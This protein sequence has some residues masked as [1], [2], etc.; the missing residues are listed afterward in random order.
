MQHDDKPQSTR[1]TVNS[2]INIFLFFAQCIGRPMQALT[3][4]PGSAGKKFFGSFTFGAGLL[5]FLPAMAFAIPLLQLP[6]GQDGFGGVFLFW[7]LLIMAGMIQRATG[8]I[9]RAKGYF[10]HTCYWG[11]A[12]LPGLFTPTESGKHKVRN[13]CLLSLL[14]GCGFGLLTNSVPLIFYGWIALIAISVQAAFTEMQDEARID[15]ALDAEADAE[16]MAEELRKRRE[17]RR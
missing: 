6:P 8:H 4:R 7:L 3:T 15:A 2:G 9:K 10:V 13:D 11:I 5:M 14:W 12:L 16:W 17:R 1:E